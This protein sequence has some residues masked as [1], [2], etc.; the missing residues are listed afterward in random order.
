MQYDIVPK[1]S[2]LKTRTVSVLNLRRNA[3]KEKCMET[4]CHYFSIHNRVAE[5][6]CRLK[7][8]MVFN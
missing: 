7:S 2:R 1:S 6:P 5:W 4:N 3:W 8:V